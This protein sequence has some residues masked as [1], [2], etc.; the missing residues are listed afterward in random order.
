M[1]HFQIGDRVFCPGFPYLGEKTIVKIYETQ[2][3]TEFIARGKTA[4]FVQGTAKIFALAKT[5]FNQL[6]LL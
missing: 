5:E 2:K 1:K 6:S 4:P 3:K